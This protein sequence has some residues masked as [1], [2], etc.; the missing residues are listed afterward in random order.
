M[1][2][3][4]DSNASNSSPTNTTTSTSHDFGQQLEPSRENKNLQPEN[5]TCKN[6]KNI[7]I[8]YSTD[9]NNPK[10]TTKHTAPEDIDLQE[11]IINNQSVS[12]VNWSN[13]SLQEIP[14]TE[15][16]PI[17]EKNL[18]QECSVEINKILDHLNQNSDSTTVESSI[19]RIRISPFLDT[20][21]DGHYSLLDSDSSHCTVA[22]SENINAH[23]ENI[24][25]SLFKQQCLGYNGGGY[26]PPK[27][28]NQ[29]SAN[30]DRLLM[31][32][33]DA[34]LNKQTVDENFPKLLSQIK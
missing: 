15:E 31:N 14:S 23:S 2:N 34:D 10:I 32:E 25:L 29:I 11:L 20:K 16:F 19:Q 26:V 30:I 17:F 7:T 9:S 28:Q 3:I 24:A 18:P 27:I 21:N 12:P 22:I 8:T 33:N 4:T 5:F 1:P 13:S 6:G